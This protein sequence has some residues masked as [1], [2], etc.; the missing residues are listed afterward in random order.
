MRTVVDENVPRRLVGALRDLNCDVAAFPRTWKGLK[1]GKLLAELG[2]N[3]FQCLITCDKSLAFQQT[4]DRWGLAVIVLPAQR[5]HLL[6][7]IAH[8]IARAIREIEIGQVASIE[9]DGGFDLRS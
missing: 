1:N 5:F 3:G 6:L 9:T 7:P 2:S 4:L 8:G